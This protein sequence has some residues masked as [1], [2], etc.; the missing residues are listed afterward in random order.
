RE[1]DRTTFRAARSDRQDDA[2]DPRRRDGRGIDD[3]LMA[4]REVRDGR[5]AHEGPTT[6]SRIM[7]PNRS[8][9]GRRAGLSGM[10]MRSVLAHENRPDEDVL[11]E[12]Y[13]RFAQ[14][15][16]FL[17]VTHFIDHATMGAEALV[18]LGMGGRVEK[19]ISRHRVR[20]Y[21]APTQGNFDPLNWKAVLGR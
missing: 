12:V 10:T 11:D 9:I 1:C 15:D 2:R 16:P 17:P 13:G 3:W 18:G 7:E 20:P 19:W 6:A 21:K 14:S 8:H 4:Q 5:L